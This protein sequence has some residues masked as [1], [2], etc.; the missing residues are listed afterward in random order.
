MATTRRTT[1]TSKKTTTR[2]SKSQKSSNGAGRV[3]LVIAALIVLL[4]V[5]R[6]LVLA[7][8]VRGQVPEAKLQTALE[9]CMRENVSISQLSSLQSVKAKESMGISSSLGSLQGIL[10]DIFNGMSAGVVETQITAQYIKEIKVL[11]LEDFFG[12]NA[13]MRI[14]GEADVRHQV[15]VIGILEDHKQYQLV[16]NKR[17]DSFNFMRVSVKTADQNDWSVWECAQQF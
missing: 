10:T 3:L 9:T 14:N 12:K 2:R 16:L 6:Q 4:V 15:P 13:Q 1:K 17:A 7:S 5:Y 11:G 8:Y